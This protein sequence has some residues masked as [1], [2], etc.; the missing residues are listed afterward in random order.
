MFHF[1]YFVIETI[2]VLNALG[3]YC[4]HKRSLLSIWCFVS[5]AVLLL[6]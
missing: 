3:L 6:N 2:E 4:L 5:L 1:R